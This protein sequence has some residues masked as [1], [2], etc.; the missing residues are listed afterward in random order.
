MVAPKAFRRRRLT[1]AEVLE[2]IATLQSEVF[3]QRVPPP[4]A[5]GNPVKGNELLTIKGGRSYDPCINDIYFRDPLS[6]LEFEFGSHRF[7]IEKVIDSPGPNALIDRLRT[8]LNYNK[9]RPDI[10]WIHIPCNS[11]EYAEVN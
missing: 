3:Q 1:P 6:G 10:R 7:P 5:L 2:E 4:V 8:E 9:R 11:M